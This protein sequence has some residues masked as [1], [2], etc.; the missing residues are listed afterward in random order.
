M[1][2]HSREDIEVAYW[3]ILDNCEEIEDFRKYVILIV[4]DSLMIFVISLF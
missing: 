4:Q 3:Y 1:N 2:E